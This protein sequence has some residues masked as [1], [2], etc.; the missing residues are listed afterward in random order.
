M[1]L[2]TKTKKQLHSLVTM[3]TYLVSV[4]LQSTSFAVDYT[5]Y[6][7]IEKVKVITEEYISQTVISNGDAS[8]L[9][10]ESTVIIDE[11]GNIVSNK[12]FE[13]PTALSDKQIK[14]I[15]QYIDHLDEENIEGVY[16]I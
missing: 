2:N 13:A 7:D 5:S 12:D 10:P 9:F 11:E 4:F 1:Y 8:V 6:S 16:S 14:G 3:F 15:V